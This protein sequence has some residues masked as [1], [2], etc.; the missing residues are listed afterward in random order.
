MCSRLMTPPRYASRT[1]RPSRPTTHPGTAVAPAASRPALPGRPA[2]LRSGCTREPTEG[3]RRPSQRLGQSRAVND[4][5][6]D[7]RTRRRA[8]QDH[9]LRSVPV[10]PIRCV[11]L[12]ARER[13]LH[14]LSEQLSERRARRR[15]RVRAEP[16]LTGLEAFRERLRG[17]PEIDADAT[18]L[19][20]PH[21]LFEAVRHESIRAS[22]SGAT[23]S[24]TCQPY[25]R[26]STAARAVS[27]AGP[28]GDDA[29]TPG[30]RSRTADRERAVPTP[31]LLPV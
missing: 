26:A 31:R 2:S 19:A 18:E 25:P 29:D 10:R 8:R 28:R 22:N 23:G 3:S 1:R 27:R 30:R 11:P 15:R 24:R 9:R 12:E 7:G 13:R 14:H 5:R 20:V 6:V 17:D 16:R 21:I 4:G